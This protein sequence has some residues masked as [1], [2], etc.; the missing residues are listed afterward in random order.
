M[1]L[2]SHTYMNKYVPMLFLQIMKKTL[3]SRKTFWKNGKLFVRKL[4]DIENNWE[5]TWDE[6]SQISKGDHY[7]AMYKGRNFSFVLKRIGEEKRK[8]KY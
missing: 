6:C 8:G 4:N 3:F 2:F 1:H 5:A 7:T